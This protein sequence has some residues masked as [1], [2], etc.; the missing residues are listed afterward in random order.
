MEGIRSF[1]NDLFEWSRRDHTLQLWIVAI[2]ILLLRKL[3]Q[4][5]NLACAFE[6]AIQ[7]IVWSNVVVTVFFLFSKMRD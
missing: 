3:Y 6:G 4:Q 1:T 7:A 5:C 2:V